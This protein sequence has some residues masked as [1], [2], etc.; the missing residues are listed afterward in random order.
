MNRFSVLMVMIV[1]ALCSSFSYASE[2]GHSYV[3]D[4]MSFIANSDVNLEAEAWAMCAASYTVMSE[5]ILDTRPIQAKKLAELANGA[6]LAVTMSIF[7]EDLD[8][9]V[10]LKKMD[11]L[12]KAAVIIGHQL[13]Q[14]RKDI[15][16]ADAEADTVNNNGQFFSDLQATVKVCS[17][18]ILSQQFYVDSWRSLMQ[19]GILSSHEFGEERAGDK[20]EKI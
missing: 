6:E 12:W 16:L 11:T 10:S 15:L 9:D 20:S 2:N 19:S 3:D 14:I 8:P 13:P 18:N 1:G 5:I 4:S 7:T 17:D